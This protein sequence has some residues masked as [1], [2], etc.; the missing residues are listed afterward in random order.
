MSPA[1]FYPYLKTQP[2][3]KSFLEL[4]LIREPVFEQNGKSLCYLVTTLWY[5]LALDHLLKT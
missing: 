2:A 4:R 3:T 5:P 1:R